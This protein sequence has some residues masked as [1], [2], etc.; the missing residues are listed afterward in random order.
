MAVFRVIYE[1]VLQRWQSEMD[2]H[3]NDKWKTI[4][5]RVSYYFQLV[6][7]SY[8]PSGVCISDDC[9]KCQGW[10]ELRLENK[11]RDGFQPD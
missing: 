7:W 11:R 9:P 4:A 8:A 1:D 3:A 6:R 5:S 2:Q 10:L